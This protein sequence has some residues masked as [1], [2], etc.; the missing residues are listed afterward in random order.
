MLVSFIIQI[1]QLS[2]NS[3][4]SPKFLTLLSDSLGKRVKLEFRG[5]TSDNLYVDIRGVLKK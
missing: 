1:A 3:L 4:A 5:P 2:Y